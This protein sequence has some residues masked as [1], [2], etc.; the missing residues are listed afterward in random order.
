MVEVGKIGD[1]TLVLDGRYISIFRGGT[2][3]NKWIYMGYLL[4][5]GNA[6]IY[7]RRV[8]IKE[9]S[10]NTLTDYQIK[11]EIGAGDPIWEHAR[12]A[13]ED[14]RFCYHPE[15]E[16]LS[17]WIEKYD[18]DAEEAIIWVKVPEIPANSE[19]E[20]Y[21]YYGNPE[22]PSASDGDATF[23]LF[24]DFDDGV[25]DTSKW[26]TYSYTTPSFEETPEGMLRVTDD[27][28]NEEI[29]Y[30]VSK[31]SFKAS[32]FGFALRVRSRYHMTSGTWSHQMVVGILHDGTYYVDK[33]PNAYWICHNP[34][35]SGVYLMSPSQSKLDEG[36][37]FATDGEFYVRELRV[38][39]GT[40]GTI[41]F[42]R[43]DGL[44]LSW[45]GSYEHTEGYV[46]IGHRGGG[47]E[48]GWSEF[49]WALV[50]KYTEPEPSVSVGGEE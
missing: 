45:S 20:I 4:P 21:M 12:S 26:D 34:T 16:M 23:E 43:D 5:D 24:D 47:S 32:D 40:S 35:Y 18:P 19:I 17:Y 29:G 46:V 13:G 38:T 7:R 8:H 42:W 11:I 2:L 22:V 25:Q 44:T 41:S 3:M 14:I 28:S 31:K 48:Q 27:S 1:K 33:E 30:Y 10:G 36:L 9:L 37:P 49:D 50:R 39:K 6:Y 15:E